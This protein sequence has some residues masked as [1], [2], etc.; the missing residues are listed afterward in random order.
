MRPNGA[1]VM[2]C[3]SIEEKVNWW[4]GIEIKLK[5]FQVSACQNNVKIIPYFQVCPDTVV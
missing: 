2:F 3:P 1:R 5:S 4:I